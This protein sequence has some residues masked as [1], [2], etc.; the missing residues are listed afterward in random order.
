MGK[1]FADDQINTLPFLQPFSRYTTSLQHSD[2]F[3]KETPK[4]TNWNEKFRFAF[5]LPNGR[6]FAT[7]KLHKIDLQNFFESPGWSCLDPPE[8]RGEPA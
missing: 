5:V 7:V 3:I 6:E 1:D 2:P 8:G 4:N